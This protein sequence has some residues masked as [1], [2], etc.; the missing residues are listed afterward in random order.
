MN[1]ETLRETIDWAL[2]TFPQL[3]DV[4]GQADYQGGFKFSSGSMQYRRMSYEVASFG[5]TVG[6]DLLRPSSKALTQVLHP[7]PPGVHLAVSNKH[8]YKNSKHLP[9]VAVADTQ[10]RAMSFVK[11]AERNPD[12]KHLFLT[13]PASDRRLKAAELNDEIDRCFQKERQFEEALL[14]RSGDAVQIACLRLELPYDAVTRTF[15][16]HFHAIATCDEGLCID[17]FQEWLR[18][19]IVDTGF[20]SVS[21]DASLVSQEHVGKVLR[22]IF[23]PCLSAYK[24]AQAGHSDEF[25]IFVGELKKRVSR[26]RGEYASFEKKRRAAA[27]AE[28]TDCRPEDSATQTNDVASQDGQEQPR[29][30]ELPEG[31]PNEPQNV[32]CGVSDSVVL[33]GGRKAAWSTVMNFV[34]TNKGM[35]NRFGDTSTV[36]LVNAAALASWEEN[37]GREYSLKEFL[38]PFWKEL[39]EVLEGGNV[40]Y[41]TITCSPEILE[42]LEEIRH[43][44]AVAKTSNSANARQ[45]V[46]WRGLQPVL[47]WF[48]FDV[49]SFLTRTRSWFSK[50]LLHFVRGSRS[51]RH[52]E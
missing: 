23:K 49:G 21:C 42:V 16:P 19:Y 36:D 4:G 32:L 25:R 24:M 50:Q 34:P 9:S 2:E 48:P 22:Y 15:Y 33:P 17:D 37:T 8:S 30:E 27:K 45:R 3:K 38:R 7:L 47:S 20:R 46:E 29:S 40:P 44:E 35:P 43:E 1:E 39:I 5:K 11:F 10:K 26:N 31:V 12:R 18:E 51:D 6:I 13:L 14:E 28:R 41:C 52:I